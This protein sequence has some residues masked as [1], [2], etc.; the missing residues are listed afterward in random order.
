MMDA[1]LKETQAFAIVHRLGVMSR[2][3]WRAWLRQEYNVP[4]AE[5]V[6]IDGVPIMADVAGLDDHV[7]RMVDMR[8]GQIFYEAEHENPDELIE[9]EGFTTNGGEGGDDEDP[10]GSLSEETLQ[11]LAEEG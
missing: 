4:L 3:E 6:Q 9:A 10:F 2:E 5:P 1:F 7:A 11:R 8:V